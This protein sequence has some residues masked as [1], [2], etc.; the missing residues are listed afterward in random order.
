M[1]ADTPSFFPVLDD[2]QLPA[3]ESDLLAA[4]KN[5][6]GFVPNLERVLAQAP[7]A[8]R[9]YVAL[10]DLISATSLTPVAQQV[11]CQQIN[12]QHDCHYCLA[13][14]DVLLKQAGADAATRK[15]LLSGEPLPDEALEALRVFTMT[16]VAE[17]GFVSGQAQDAFLSAGYTSA[18]MLEIIA[19]LACKVISNYSNHLAGTPLEPFVRPV[20]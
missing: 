9:A 2:N 7:A 8:L 12:R 20:T 16:L 4:V 14:H 1:S 13:H 19:I 17:R 3:S 10:W 5:D 18:Q 6:F 15:A 11:V